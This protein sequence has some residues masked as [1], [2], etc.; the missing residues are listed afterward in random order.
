MA[1]HAFNNLSDQYSAMKLITRNQIRRLTEESSPVCVSLYMPI[2]NTAVDEQRQNPIRFKNLRRSA[3]EK[4]TKTGASPEQI[5]K[6]FNNLGDINWQDAIGKERR[7]IGIFLSTASSRIFGLPYEIPEI[8]FVQNRYYLRPLLPFLSTSSPFYIVVMNAYRMRLYQ[9]TKYSIEPIQ[10]EGISDDFSEE[11]WN[12]GR[13]GH[14]AYAA[15]SHEGKTNVRH[16]QG[17]VLEDTRVD[18]LTHLRQFNDAV[19]SHLEHEEEPLV[20]LGEEHLLGEFEKMNHYQNKV[21]TKVHKN[22]EGLTLKDIQ[23]EA[24]H[25]ATLHLS[26]KRNTEFEKYMDLKGTGRIVS[27]LTDVLKAADARRIEA[28]FLKLQEQSWGSFDRANQNVKFSSEDTAGADDLIDLAAY[29]TLQA[30]GEVY[31]SLEEQTPDNEIIA[32]VLRF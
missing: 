27:D 6:I 17:Q 25:A 19:M 21:A 18:T 13:N 20:L 22:P 9:A 23:Q 4:L 7:G 14:T 26:A 12:D 10:L 3:E 5:S 16:P 31:A 2:Y 32:A 8:A 29:K 15:V 30:N 11:R 1:A 24:L 28:L